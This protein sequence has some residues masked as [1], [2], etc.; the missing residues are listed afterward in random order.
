[1]GASYQND[2]DYDYGG[3]VDEFG[4]T[5][6]KEYQN[7]LGNVFLDI[8]GD[9]WRFNGAYY[10]SKKE[11]LAIN[12][13]LQH[14]GTNDYE[15]YYL[16]LNKKFKIGSGTLNTS[17]RYDYTQRDINTQQCPN[18]FSGN[19]IVAEN[20]IKRYSAEIRYKDKF[21][22]D[23]SYTVGANYEYDNTDPFLF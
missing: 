1:M 10:N 4:Q 9:D 18:P 17:L 16:D 5:I 15:S 19:P 23:L 21:S 3:T 13:I 11:K 8:H 2:D 20:D 6:D 14:G 22:D 12:P 7:D